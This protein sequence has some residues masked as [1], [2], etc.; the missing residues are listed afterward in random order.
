M[1]TC[2]VI[3][4]TPHEKSYQTLTTAKARKVNIISTKHKMKSI[5]TFPHSGKKVKRLVTVCEEV[6]GDTSDAFTYA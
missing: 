2:K 3:E 6:S 1:K 4:A 5:L